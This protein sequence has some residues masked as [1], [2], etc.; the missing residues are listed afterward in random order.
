MNP[1]SIIKD[2]VL[3]IGLTALVMGYAMF[4]QLLLTFVA[5]SYIHLEIED[6][7]RNACICTVAADVIYLVRTVRRY[8]K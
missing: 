6:M 5:L 3:F 4:L 8:R 7:F 2:I 1:K